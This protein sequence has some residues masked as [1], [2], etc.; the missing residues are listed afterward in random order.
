MPFSFF[1]FLKNIFFTFEFVHFNRI[2]S[3][4]FEVSTDFLMYFL[5][6]EKKKK[7]LVRKKKRNTILI[8]FFFFF[9]TNIFF[10]ADRIFFF[11]LFLF[12]AFPIRSVC[13]KQKKKKKLKRILIL[14][15]HIIIQLQHNMSS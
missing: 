11:F 1:F 14:L 8:F 6:F 15:K 13:G 4:Q 10:F 3:S 2:R 5:A 7:K 12:G 9:L